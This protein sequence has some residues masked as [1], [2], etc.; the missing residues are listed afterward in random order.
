M[1]DPEKEA[2]MEFFAAQKQRPGDHGKGKDL[3][4]EIA[5]LVQRH[6]KESILFWD[7][8]TIG[9]L[10]SKN[11]PYSRQVGIVQISVAEVSID[12]DLSWKINT[13]VNPEARIPVEAS[14]VHGIY[15]KDV[16]D[17]PRF[18]ELADRIKEFFENEKTC[19]CGYNSRSFDEKYL[20]AVYLRHNIPPVQY[21]HT[22]DARDFWTKTMKT[23]KGKLTETAAYYGAVAG[24]AHD[25]S[26]DVLTLVRTVEKMIE[27][28]GLEDFVSKC[29]LVRPDQEIAKNEKAPPQGKRTVSLDMFWDDPLGLYPRKDLSPPGPN[30]PTDRGER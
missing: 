25:S 10:P 9:L 3:F 16:V 15:D 8:E 4:P 21:L 1:Y 14:N 30:I 5:K 28:H 12:G 13:I 6:E 18:I 24:R 7:L 19:L 20:Q 26:G 2:L 11:A 17:A 22:L 29:A 23:N 27:R